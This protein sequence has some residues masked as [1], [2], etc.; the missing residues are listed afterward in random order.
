MSRGLSTPTTSGVV[1]IR[2]QGVV[3]NLPRRVGPQAQPGEGI[4]RIDALPGSGVYSRHIGRRSPGR[5]APPAPCPSC[6]ST[7]SE[8]DGTGS[9]RHVNRQARGETWSTERKHMAQPQTFRTTPFEVKTQCRRYEGRVA[10]ITGGAQ[11]LG[12]VVA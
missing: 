12:R 7:S 4:V 8:A 11:G 5:Q 1:R 6:T 3:V 2:Q 9:Y 10:I